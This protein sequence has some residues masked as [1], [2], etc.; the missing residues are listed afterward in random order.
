MT[1]RELAQNL[2]DRAK[3]YV[4]SRASHR[5]AF[6]TGSYA[7]GEPTED[8]D[9]DLVVLSRY[10]TVEQLR[11]LSEKVEWTKHPASDPGGEPTS[12]SLKFGNLNLIVVADPRAFE[13]WRVGTDYL[14]GRKRRTARDKAIKL[15]K[16]MRDLAG[17]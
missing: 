15:F 12:A 7:Y 14:V 6:L 5:E 11:K 9:I 17:V 4:K 10:E 8:S 13:V 1:T 3:R 16:A 2:Y